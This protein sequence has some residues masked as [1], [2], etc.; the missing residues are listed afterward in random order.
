MNLQITY[1]KKTFTV[2]FLENGVRYPNRNIVRKVILPCV[3]VINDQ[4]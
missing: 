3:S 4:T 1:C 2:E